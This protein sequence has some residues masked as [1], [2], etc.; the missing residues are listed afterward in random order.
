MNFFST[1]QNVY[2]YRSVIG[3]KRERMASSLLVDEN[4]FLSVRSFT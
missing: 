2:A 4:V 3:Q 1:F